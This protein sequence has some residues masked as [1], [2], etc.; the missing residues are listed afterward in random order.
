[1]SVTP[2]SSQKAHARLSPK[3]HARLATP[4][5]PHTRVTAPKTRRA[6]K[7]NKRAKLLAFPCCA[8]INRNHTREHERKSDFRF[9]VG[10]EAR[11]PPW[12][13]LVPIKF[14]Y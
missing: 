1:M 6:A 11:N 5:P 13:D 10:N 14:K 8:P 4:T 3:S 9:E 7:V 12:R 2:P